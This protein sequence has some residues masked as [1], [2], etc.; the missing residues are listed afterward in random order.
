[1][2]GNLRGRLVL[3]TFALIKTHKRDDWTREDWEDD[4]YTTLAHE[5]THHVEGLA[6]ERGLEIR[7]QL[8]LEEYRR[9]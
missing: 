7:D 4:L 2:P 1:M 5:F 9:E 6:C 3:S 8:E